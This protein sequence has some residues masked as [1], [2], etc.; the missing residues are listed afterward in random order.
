MKFANLLLELVDHLAEFP[1]HVVMQKRADLLANRVLHKADQRL[2]DVNSFV[3]CDYL[4]SKVL[5]RV[6]SF[7]LI[8]SFVFFLSFNEFRRFELFATSPFPTK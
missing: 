5:K 1:L 6:H 8:A 7:Q 4:S 2:Q 3:F